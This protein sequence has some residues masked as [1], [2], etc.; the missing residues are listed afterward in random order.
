LNL[1]PFTFSSRW[2]KILPS[3]P[4][5]EKI[6]KYSVVKEL[7]QG[8]MGIVYLAR[9]PFLE[10]KVAIKTLP[11]TLQHNLQRFQRE[12]RIYAILDY[13]HIVKLFE[14]FEENENHYL[15]MEYLAGGDL[16][17][18]IE[19]QISRGSIDLK[20][21]CRIFRQICR[22]VEYAHQKGIFHR[23]LKPENI[24][25]TE[26]GLPK[27][28]DFGLACLKSQRPITESNVHFGT[29]I[30]SSPEQFRG[31]EVDHRTDIYSLSILLYELLTNQLPFTAE[32]LETAVIHGRV[33]RDPVSPRQH[34][35]AIPELLEEL[36]LNNLQ[37]EPECRH[38]SV[39]EMV[40]ILNRF[41]EP[42]KTFTPTVNCPACLGE[43]PAGN[44]YC[45]Q[46]GK[47]LK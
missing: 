23:D 3:M 2:D 32:E 41:L 47:A 36:I 43:N 9:D 37:P 16:Y 24:L 4:V 10:R 46:C 29:V 8:G 22:A 14:H 33:H 17:K 34:N 26:D 30:Y 45:G 6:G 42:E 11:K 15:V 39:G 20:E 38:Q 44:R 5:I 35:Q 19:D 31:M 21:N 1:Q 25:L 28:A 27:V 13:P 12:A 18:W 7:G 40:E